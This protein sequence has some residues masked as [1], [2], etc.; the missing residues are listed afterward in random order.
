MG[1][2]TTL[3]GLSISALGKTT[4]SAAGVDIAGQLEVC[5]RDVEMLL[6]RLTPIVTIL[7]AADA[8]SS[9]SN[10]EASNISA[11]NT[12]LTNLA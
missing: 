1:T 6:L 9:G 5:I 8:A 3:A 4:G 12:I 11:I 10:P 7:T 2:K